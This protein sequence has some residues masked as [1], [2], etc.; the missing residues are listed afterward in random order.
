M[1]NARVRACCP[2]CVCFRSGPKEAGKPL[3]KNCWALKRGQ[4]QQKKNYYFITDARL[5]WVFFK[6]AIKMMMPSY[7]HYE[8][9][10]YQ[11]WGLN[12][13]QVFTFHWTSPASLSLYLPSACPQLRDMTSANNHKGHTA[14]VKTI[15]VMS[16]RLPLRRQKPLPR[17][18]ILFHQ[19]LSAT[20]EAQ[21]DTTFGKSLQWTAW[22]LHFFF[23]LLIY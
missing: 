4:I 17:P 7:H 15:N 2:S 11:W 8:C 14:C 16:D 1:I 3:G 19:S 9:A 10:S 6:R 13:T 23:L 21:H 5:F 18:H 12:R 22:L 20:E